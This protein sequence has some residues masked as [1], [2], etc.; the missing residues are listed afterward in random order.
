MTNL[1]EFEE[2][3]RDLIEINSWNL[4]GGTE[5]NKRNQSREPKS[6][7]KFLPNTYINTSRS[8]LAPLNVRCFLYISCRLVQAKAS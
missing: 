5:E 7:P 6:R 2:R 3:D 4:S 1:N 8:V